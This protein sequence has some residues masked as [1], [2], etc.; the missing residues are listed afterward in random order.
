MAGPPLI[1]GVAQ[2]TSLRAACGLLAVAGAVVVA[3]ATN[4]APAPLRACATSS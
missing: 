2:L 1:G 3:L 4:A